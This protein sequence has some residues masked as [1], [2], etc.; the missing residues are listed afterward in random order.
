MQKV[1]KIVKNVCISYFLKL[2]EFNN[3]KF[4]V[5]IQCADNVILNII[6]APINYKNIS[7]D[8]SSNQN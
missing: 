2:K 8:N 7:W 5:V 1:I 6:Y 3:K 4:S